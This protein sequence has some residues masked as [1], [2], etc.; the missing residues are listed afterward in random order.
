[1]KRKWLTIGIILLFIGTCILPAIAQDTKTPLPT[2]RG[3]WFYVGGSGP[4]NFTRIQD[5]INNASEGD[6]VFVYDDSSP[7]YENICIDKEI[8]VLGE[9]KNSTIIDGRQLDSIVKITANNSS[10][11]QFTLLNT[12]HFT[13]V[14]WIGSFHDVLVRNNIIQYHYTGGI[15]CDGSFCEFSYNFLQVVGGIGIE[16]HF[17][18]DLFIHHNSIQGGTSGISLGSNNCIIA[19]NVINDTLEGICFDDGCYAN[20]IYDNIIMNNRKGVYMQNSFLNSFYRNSFITNNI[21][22]FFINQFVPVY[23]RWV[24]NYWDDI[25]VFRIKCIPGIYF[26][27]PG[28]VINRSNFDWFPAKEPYNIPGMR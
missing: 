12:T 19:N 2:L 13:D 18:S 21:S 3:N 8:K 15:N 5:A 11:E 6:T 20:K 7:Y 28:F 4:G 17:T 22:A 1:M 24:R 26:I 25:G 10:I 23:N 16:S 9:D 14:I 27:T